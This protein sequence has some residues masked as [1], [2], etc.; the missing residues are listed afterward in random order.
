MVTRH[1]QPEVGEEAAS[2]LQEGASNIIFGGTGR[3]ESR[4]TI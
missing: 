4:L 1:I 2:V 3:P